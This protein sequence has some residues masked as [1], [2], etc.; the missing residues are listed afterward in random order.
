MSNIKI[1]ISHDLTAMNIMILYKLTITTLLDFI[2]KID[3]TLL[4]PKLCPNKS[5]ASVMQMWV[6]Y[7]QKK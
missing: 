6:Y 2:Y 5:A 4:F 7:A 1:R 3:L